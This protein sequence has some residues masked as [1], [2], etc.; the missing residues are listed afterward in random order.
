MITLRKIDPSPV[1]REF[2]RYYM[3]RQGGSEGRVV[4]RPIPARP[5]IFLGFFL[6]HSYDAFDYRSGRTETLPSALVVGPQTRHVA[7][8]LL[9][10]PHAEF[11]VYFEPAGFY[12]LFGVSPVEL[13]NRADDASVVVGPR[14][15]LLLEEL[16]RATNVEAMVRAV[17][18]FLL[19]HAA[20]ARPFH[21]VQQAASIVL[22][23]KGR[24]SLAEL[25][26]ASGVGERQF[27]RKFTEQIGMTPKL[28]V[29]VV[30]LNHA[31]QLKEQR[32]TLTWTEV[33]HRAGYF[34]QT[35]LVK[36][37]KALTGARPSDFMRRFTEAAPE[38]FL[39]ALS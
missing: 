21:P 34:D 25:I 16:R 31:L 2:V 35:H 14:A 17:E 20:S 13:V 24:V 26:G 30:R 33:S 6:L 9:E 27:E 19:A 3:Y 32:P 29:R 12:R 23:N 39:P 10:G 18:C 11:F 37:F 15:G 8:L 38:A 22:R 28:Y 1:V 5:D 4:A 7:D 36:D